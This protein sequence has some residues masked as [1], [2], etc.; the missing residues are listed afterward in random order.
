MT[1]TPVQLQPI[2]VAWQ[3]A[4]NQL[5]T[6]IALANASSSG[7]SITPTGGGSLIDVAGATWTFGTNTGNGGTG[8]FRNGAAAASGQGVKLEVDVNG[9][10]WTQNAQNNWYMWNGSGWTAEASGPTI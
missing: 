6:L 10:I 5:N 9:V 2:A 3:N 7:S 8:I 1:I 4:L